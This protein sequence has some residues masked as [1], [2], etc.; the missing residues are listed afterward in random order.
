MKNK[1]LKRIFYALKHSV[2]GIIAAL[3]EEAAF[4]QILIVSIIGLICAIIFGEKYEI[5][6]LALPSFLCVIVELL[7]SAIEN[8]VD[9]TGKEFSPLAKKAKDM[10]SGAQL[11]STIYF[12]FTWAIFACIKIL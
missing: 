2:N 7:N 5:L 9:Y 8:A 3:R 1:G 11:F 10:A 4:R 6:L 12:I